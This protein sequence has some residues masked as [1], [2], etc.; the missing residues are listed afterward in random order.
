VIT[1]I[2][3]A[4]VLTALASLIAF[5]WRISLQRHKFDRA[6]ELIDTAYLWGG[7][8]AL[9]DMT[10]AI[11]VLLTRTTPEPRYTRTW[12]VLGRRSAKAD[13]PDHPRDVPQSGG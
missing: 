4:S 13:P 7:T 3:V 9:D 8:E 11:D 1:E 12:P 6:A 10:K 2:V 5:R